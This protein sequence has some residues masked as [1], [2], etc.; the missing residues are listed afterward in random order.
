[1]AFIKIDDEFIINTRHVVSF[2]RL[3]TEEGHVQICFST[4]E[5]EAV[6]EDDLDEVWNEIIKAESK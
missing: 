2:T 6:R 5:K 1:M 3:H 4:G